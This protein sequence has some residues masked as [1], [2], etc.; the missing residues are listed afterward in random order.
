MRLFVY[1]TAK[2]P[3]ALAVFECEKFSKSKATIPAH[4]NIESVKPDMVCCPGEG[5]QVDRDTT[6]VVISVERNTILFDREMGT[7]QTFPL[8]EEEPKS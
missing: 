6:Y 8:A 5:R 2:S 1:Q 7:P 3:K 4:V